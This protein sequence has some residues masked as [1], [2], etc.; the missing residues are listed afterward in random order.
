M[1]ATSHIKNL[2]ASSGPFSCARHWRQSTINSAT[3]L[4]LYILQNSP[5]HW[6]LQARPKSYPLRTHLDRVNA[7]GHVW[8]GKGGFESLGVEADGD[9]LHLWRAWVRG[10][11]GGAVRFKVSVGQVIGVWGQGRGRDGCRCGPGIAAGVQYVTRPL[12]QG[13][14]G[15]EVLAALVPCR[16]GRALGRCLPLWCL[17]EK[18][19]H[20]GG[21]PRDT[22]GLNGWERPGH[23]MRA[24]V[25]MS[26]PGATWI[27]PLP[28]PT[29][30]VLYHFPHP[31]SSTTSHIHGPLPLPTSMDRTSTTSHIHGP[32]PLPT[33]MDRTSTTSHI[34]GL[35]APPCNCF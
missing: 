25:M 33:S 31:W 24:S 20:W 28:S 34:H 6:E 9:P 29:S 1:D 17:A 12:L 11:G 30:M 5:R 14:P 32:L 35:A 23:G 3:A 2:H 18:A 13:A 19:G 4:A 21:P 15:L 8:R 10:S 26:T 16:K 7:L 27:R 22:R